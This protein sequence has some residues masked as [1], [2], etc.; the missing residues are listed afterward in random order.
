MPYITIIYFFNIQH[1]SIS[2]EFLKRKPVCY[3]GILTVFLVFE[4]YMFFTPLVP[5]IH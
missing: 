1:S 5:G 2:Q 3:L 4:W